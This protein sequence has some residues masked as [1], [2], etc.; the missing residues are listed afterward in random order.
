MKTFR[1]IA[2]FRIPIALVSLVLLLL[3]YRRFVNWQVECR[4][5]VY[6]AAMQD[7][8]VLGMI[9]PIIALL[10]IAKISDIMSASRMLAF[11]SRDN[12]WKVLTRTLMKEC[13]VMT[14][15]LLF[16]V[17][18]M[19]NM[20]MGVMPAWEEI[21]YM[22]FTLLTCFLYFCFI[23]ACMVTVKIVIRQSM[24]AFVLAL[25]ISYLP[26]VPASFFRSLQLPGIGSIFS[27]RYALSE[28][29]FQWVWCQNVCVVLLCLAGLMWLIGK[30]LLQRQDIFWRM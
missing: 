28:N 5:D 16:P 29:G 30:R 12:W 27:L 7:I 22:L 11:G 9:I 3:V 10:S 19:I 20:C 26:N 6:V 4:A 13:L 8:V 14:G 18:I 24:A 23:A 25:V 17:W 15:L 1:K 2:V 21:L